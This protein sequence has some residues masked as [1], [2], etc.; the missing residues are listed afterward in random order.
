MVGC[1]D[2]SCVGFMPLNL[3]ALSA[4]V[5]VRGGFLTIAWIRWAVL[6]CDVNIDAGAIAVIRRCPIRGAR[7]NRVIRRPNHYMRA[8]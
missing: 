2:F 3:R 7:I 1:G 5:K 4:P 6:G 8:A